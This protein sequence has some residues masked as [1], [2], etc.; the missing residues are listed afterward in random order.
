LKEF[1]LN[2]S[3]AVRTFILHD[4]KKLVNNIS[5]TYDVVKPYKTDIVKW[6]SP[7]I[8]LSNFYVY[9]INGITEG[10]NW[11]YYK[12][13]RQVVLNEGEY[14]WIQEKLG[15]DG[16]IKYQS[17]PNSSDGNFIQVP[18]NIPVALDLAYVGSTKIK[19]IPVTDNIEYV[20]YSLSKSFGV[21]NIRT[22]WLFT[23]KPDSKLDSLI[24]QA[25]Y[26][27]YFAHN[28]SECIINNF[29]I[30]YIYTKLENQQKSL[31]NK[32]DLIPSDSVWLATSNSND[33]A[34]YRRKDN[35]ARICLSGV[36]EPC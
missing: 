18:T 20:F 1:L 25:K 5:P 33:Y 34:K 10:L 12:E 32:L 6:L 27:N 29:D 8:D 23:K 30:D 17:V 35:I 36:Y 13:K 16:L 26:Y 11:W 19:K 22:G 4:V 24:Y 2:Q 3:L 7:I 28:I 14:Q 9:P 31:C 15:N 21:S